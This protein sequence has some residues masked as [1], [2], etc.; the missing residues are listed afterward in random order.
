MRLFRPFWILLYDHKRNKDIQ[1]ELNT[2]TITY[3]QLARVRFLDIQ[4][5]TAPLK[6]SWKER[7]RTAK[8][9]MD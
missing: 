2:T 7:S 3:N 9:A 1:M 5:E 8:E 6:T 4:Q